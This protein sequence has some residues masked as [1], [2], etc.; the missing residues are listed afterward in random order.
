[1]KSDPVH[2]HTLQWSNQPSKSDAGWQMGNTAER[3]TDFNY[4]NP[5]IFSHQEKQAGF[6]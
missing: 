5:P 1:L 4:R 3:E 2:V 6:F